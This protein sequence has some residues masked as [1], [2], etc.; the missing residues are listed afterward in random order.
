MN[1]KFLIL[2]SCLILLIVGCAKEPTEIISVEQLDDNTK[3]ITTDYSLGQNKGEQQDIIYQEDNQTFQNY[4]DPSL[5]GAFQWIKENISEGKFLSWWDYGHMIKGYSGQEVIIY[6][7]SEDILWS[8][9]SQRWDEEKSGLF[10]S[11]E[12]IE[13]VAEALTTTDLRVTTEI[14]KKY[15]ANYVFVAK[16]DKAASWVLFK[17]TGRDDYYNKENYQAAEK[18]SETVL[19]RMDDGDEFSQF[20]L[21]YDDKTAKIYKLR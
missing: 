6:S 3:I 9:A 18:A 12:K 21:V 5:R 11:T 15:K 2:F 7:P 10:S 20:E 4:F 13:D 14:M 16:K 1:L 8:L 19:F 17:I